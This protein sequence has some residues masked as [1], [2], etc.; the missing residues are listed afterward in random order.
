[1][2]SSAACTISAAFSSGSLP[3]SRL[4]SAAAFLRIAERADQLAAACAS[5]PMAKWMQRPLRSARPSSDRRAPRSAP[6]CRSRCACSLQLPGMN[7][8]RSDGSAPSGLVS[9]RLRVSVGMPTDLADG[10]VHG[11]AHVG[12][13][14][15]GGSGERRGLEVG[16]DHQPV[17][18]DPATRAFATCSASR[19][20][21]RLTDLG[22][23]RGLRARSRRR[24]P[25]CGCRAGR[26]RRPRCPRGASSG[27]SV[28]ARP[29]TAY[30]AGRVRA[31]AEHANQRSG[32]RHQH[33]VPVP[34]LRHRR[35]DGPHRV[36]RAEVV[37]VH[38]GAERGGVELRRSG[39]GRA[40]PAQTSASTSTRPRTR[41]HRRA[42]RGRAARRRSVTSAARGRHACG[43]SRGAP[44]ALRRSEPLERRGPGATPLHPGTIASASAA[45]RPMPLD[46]PVTSTWA[47][48]S[49]VTAAILPRGRACSRA[50]GRAV[51]ST[52]CP[53]PSLG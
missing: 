19:G 14:Q 1:M 16:R 3:R 38:L 47:P 48:W 34:P 12:A 40:P 7:F 2:T 8:R 22:G 23:L 51:A 10:L 44:G 27:R 26:R 21:D 15:A 45:A 20:C 18:F 41:P 11:V 50:V 43:V 30:L 52:P 29:R 33:Q 17:L 31:V 49:F 53:A 28:S 36:Q 4:T 25:A 32:R 5:P 13:E 24:S 39:P 42:D 6:C 35:H 37:D 46:P 9:A